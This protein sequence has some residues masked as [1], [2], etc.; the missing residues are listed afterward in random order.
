MYSISIWNSLKCPTTYITINTRR[1]MLIIMRPHRTSGVCFLYTIWGLST[2]WYIATRCMIVSLHNRDL[3]DQSV[4]LWPICTIFVY[5]H[6]QSARAERG[7]GCV[8]GANFHFDTC[9]GRKHTK[10]IST[11]SRG[12]VEWDECSYMPPTWC[13][14]LAGWLCARDHKYVPYVLY[15]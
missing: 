11:E 1:V 13:H 7:A 8:K 4:N 12:L 6:T 2:V 15:E 9:P 14:Y 3:D 5:A 10:H